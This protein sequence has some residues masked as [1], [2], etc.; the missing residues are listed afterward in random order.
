MAATH[1][2]IAPS[3]WF[4]WYRVSADVGKVTNDNPGLV[5][6]LSA[7]ALVPKKPDQA[8]LFD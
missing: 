7:D 2:K 1:C 5:T 4:N 8:D 3:S 6:P